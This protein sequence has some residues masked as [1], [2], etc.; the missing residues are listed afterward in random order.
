MGG[1]QDPVPLSYATP[2]SLLDIRGRAVF[3]SANE[4]Q[5]SIEN[6]NWMRRTSRNEKIDWDDV[7]SAVEN[8]GTI[9]ERASRDRTGPHGDNDFRLGHGRVSLLK[10]EAH[11]ASDGPRDQEPVGMPR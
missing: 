4:A 11:V 3:N 6:R 9:P 7:A 1:K 8:L 10:R 5:Q 2:R